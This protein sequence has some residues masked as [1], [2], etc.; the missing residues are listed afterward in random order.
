RFAGVELAAVGEDVSIL[1]SGED[2][3]ADAPLDAE[4][5]ADFLKRGDGVLIEHVGEDSDEGMRQFSQIP[6]KFSVELKVGAFVGDQGAGGLAFDEA[7]ASDAAIEIVAEV[8]HAH[9]DVDAAGLGR[10]VRGGGRGQ[11]V[12]A[13][14]LWVYGG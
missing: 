7:G 12:D 5:G 14:I 1:A 13:G 11:G 6:G 9:V 4:N 3:R 10:F 2:Q 8:V